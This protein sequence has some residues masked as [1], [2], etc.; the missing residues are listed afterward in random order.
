MLISALVASVESSFQPC[1]VPTTGVTCISL[2][3]NEINNAHHYIKM[4]SY[5]FNLQEITD[6]LCVA[7]KSGVDVEILVDKKVSKQK[8]ARRQLEQILACGGKVFVDASS[9]SIAHNKVMMID[10]ITMTTGSVNWSKAGFFKNAENLLM[11]K[12]ERKIFDSYMDNYILRK[13]MSVPYKLF[14]NLLNY[15]R[16]Y[17]A[18]E[19]IEGEF[20]SV[21]LGT[22]K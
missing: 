9:V 15:K 12:Y 17:S 10:N 18:R 2:V 6:H 4:M 14:V 20:L 5:S 7:S 1:F 11:I 16:L 8:L 3:I 19:V 22:I 21:D 13:K